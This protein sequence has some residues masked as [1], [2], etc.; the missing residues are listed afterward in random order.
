M[1]TGKYTFFYTNKSPFSNF[2]PCSF[3]VDGVLFCCGEQYMM[4]GKAKLFKDDDMARKIL[5]ETKPLKMKAYGRQVRGF[6][7][8]VW[9]QN[10]EAIVHRALTAKFGQ[11]P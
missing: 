11:N 6:D 5:A 2:Y 4:Y 10:R 1:Q 9:A 3:K 7:Q 8:R